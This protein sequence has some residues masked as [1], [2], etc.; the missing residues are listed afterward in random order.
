MVDP[1][2]PEGRPEDLTQSTRA[3]VES[4]IKTAVE[5][6]L[7]AEV[8]RSPEF[9]MS[10]SRIFNR[11]APDFS[12]TFSRGGTQLENLKFQDLA[13]ADDAAFA[14]FTERLRLLQDMGP[15]E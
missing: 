5:Q 3:M 8:V 15:S 7:V 4:T 1:E 9:A 12:R 6:A 13:M 14:K 11:D 2:S 10:F